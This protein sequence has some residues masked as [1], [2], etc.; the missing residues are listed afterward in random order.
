MASIDRAKLDRT[1]PDPEEEQAAMEEVEVDGDLV[2]TLYLMGVDLMKEGGVLPQLAQG[3][4]K[5]SDPAQVV[6]QFIVQMI[7]Q[8]AEVAAAEFNFDPRVFLAQNGWLE[9]TLDFIEDE[10]S[11]PEEFSDEVDDV[12]LE[13]IK[14]LA[15]G[16][17][18]PEAPAQAAPGI[19]GAVPPS[20]VASQQMGAEPG[21]SPF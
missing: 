15:Q 20:G 3:L 4:Q 1:V 13:M 8:L 12:V 18:Q 11:L 2:E 7:G 16:E 17:K 19:Q 6:G 14:A 21:A 10:L 9:R 5:S